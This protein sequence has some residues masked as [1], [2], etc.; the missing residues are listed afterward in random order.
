MHD[1]SGWKAIGGVGLFIF[2]WVMTD[3]VGDHWG[4]SGQVLGLAIFLGLLVAAALVVNV[5]KLN[6]QT[7]DG[8]KPN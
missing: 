2:G 4:E 1:R 6:R 7:K 3:V 5:R 8:S